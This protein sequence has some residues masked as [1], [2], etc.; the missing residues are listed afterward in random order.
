M[1]LMNAAFDP[2]FCIEPTAHHSQRTLTDASCRHH[3]SMELFAQLLL[4]TV[5]ILKM[6]ESPVKTLNARLVTLTH[7]LRSTSNKKMVL[8]SSW[9]M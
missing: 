7:P 4:P 8:N 6:T 3:S 2:P 9:G 5:V 1:P